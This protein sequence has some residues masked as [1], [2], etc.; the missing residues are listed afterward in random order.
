LVLND[1]TVN[2]CT[3]VRILV[4]RTF[5]TSNDFS[6]SEK[7]LELSELLMTFAPSKLML[8]LRAGLLIFV[9]PSKL[10]RGAVAPSEMTRGAAATS[11]IDFLPGIIFHKAGVA[12]H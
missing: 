1:S 10:A 3:W 8:E 12:A 7:T 11:E 9:A 6:P 4:S 5:G 2:G